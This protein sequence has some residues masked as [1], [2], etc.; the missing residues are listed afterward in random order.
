M[1]KFCYVIKQ[2]TKEFRM[3]SKLLCVDFLANLQEISYYVNNP[4]KKN[5]VAVILR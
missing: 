3:L 5:A 4:V 1:L 2:S